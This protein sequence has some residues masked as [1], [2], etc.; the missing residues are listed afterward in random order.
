METFAIIIIGAF[1]ANHFNGLSNKMEEYSQEFKMHLQNEKN[2]GNDANQDYY[3][4]RIAECE[5]KAIKTSRHSNL[6]ILLTIFG[7]V[8]TILT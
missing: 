3:E 7:V 6:V 4:K 5:A 2:A 8:I 1:I